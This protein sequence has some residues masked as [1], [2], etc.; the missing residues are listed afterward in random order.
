MR[1]AALLLLLSLTACSRGY[2]RGELSPTEQAALGDVLR[3]YLSA[4]E[5]HY[6]RHNTYSSNLGELGVTTDGATIRIISADARGHAAVVS[7]DDHD[8]AGC[9]VFVGNASAPSTP[10]GRAASEEGRI[11]CDTE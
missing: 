10:G 7:H 6:S 4:Q 1:R 3:A 5:T 11:V 8:D 2:G 9:A